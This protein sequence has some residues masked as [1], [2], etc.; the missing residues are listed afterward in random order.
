MLSD[1]DDLLENLEEEFALFLM[2]DGDYGMNDEDMAQLAAGLLM[3]LD[4][5]E[6]LQLPQDAWEGL[7]AMINGG[8]F[9]A[10]VGDRFRELD[11]KRRKR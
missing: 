6:L 11:R 9:P 2:N 10:E 7:W 4:E 8:D 3:N 1:E 5:E